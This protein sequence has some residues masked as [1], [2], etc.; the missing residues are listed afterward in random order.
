MRPKR[1]FSPELEASEARFLLSGVA[2]ANL[3]LK[4]DDVARGEIYYIAGKV[5]DSTTIY[6]IVVTND[7]GHRLI[8]TASAA[9]RSTLGGDL[10]KGGTV[11]ARGKF[12]LFSDDSN[13]AFTIGLTSAQDSKLSSKFA[14]AA[15]EAKQ[16]SKDLGYKFPALDHFANNANANHSA[17]FSVQIQGTG[18]DKVLTV[19]SG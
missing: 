17:P 6:S 8:L 13:A 11:A 3:A 5:F 15:D 19:V 2:H 10:S 16:T 9:G 7:T 18:A 14:F 4:V 12:L 1:S